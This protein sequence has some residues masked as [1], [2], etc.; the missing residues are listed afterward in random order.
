[1]GGHGA[2]LY[3]SQLAPGRFAAVVVMAG[4]VD[5][6]MALADGGDVDAVVTPLR[7]TPTWIL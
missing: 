2:Y 1:M 7:T 4:Y 6:L 3:A 5:E